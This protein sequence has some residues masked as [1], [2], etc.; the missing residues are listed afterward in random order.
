MW[1]HLGGVPFCSP[2]HRSDLTPAEAD[3]SHGARVARP[4]HAEVCLERR[5]GVAVEILEW[6]AEQ[7]WFSSQFCWKRSGK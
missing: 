5:A 1:C 2:W 4:R 6:G 3:R 7:P